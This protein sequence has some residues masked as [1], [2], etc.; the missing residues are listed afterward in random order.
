MDNKTETIHFETFY[1]ASESQ[2]KGWG[3]LFEAVLLSKVLVKIWPSDHHKAVSGYWKNFIPHDPGTSGGPVF[4]PMSPTSLQ[5]RGASC[6]FWLWNVCGRGAGHLKAE[7]CGDHSPRSS[8]LSWQWR[9]RSL[10]LSEGIAPWCLP[11]CWLVTEGRVEQDTHSPPTTLAG[12]YEQE[13]AFLGVKPQ[14]F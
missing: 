11:A 8:P 9:L 4:S 14:K 6:W 2:G 1:F 12:Q 3:P 7:A 10:C 5:L 13:E